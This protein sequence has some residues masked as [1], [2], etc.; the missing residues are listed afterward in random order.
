MSLQIVIPVYN[1]AKYLSKCLDSIMDKK[2]LFNG[3]VSVLVI[4]DGSTD[5][6]AE[7]IQEYQKKYPSIIQCIYQENQGL[8]E[9]RNRA[10]NKMTA[11]YFVFL[12][13][14]DWIETEK[15]L[16]L[17]NEAIKEDLDI[18][19]YR[20]RYVN[21][22]YEITGERPA[23]PVVHDEVITGYEVLKQ[24]YS[25]SSSCLFLYKTEFIIQNELF[26]HP[27]ITQQDVE[28][29]VRLFLKAR[30]VMFTDEVIYNYYR[31]VG[32]TTIPKS[33]KKLEKYLS[34]SITV[35]RLIKNNLAEVEDEKIKK[36]ITQLSN[37]VV[38]NLLWRLIQKRENLSYKCRLELITHLKTSKLYPIKPPFETNFQK[39]TSYA[40]NQ[41]WLLKFMMKI[42]SRKNSDQKVFEDKYCNAG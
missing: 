10:V 5:A 28:F 29:S 16:K 36:I 40:L 14:D 17:Y 22:D 32:S 18:L 6:S 8:S 31:R 7:I 12:D 20:L 26:Y 34:D 4:D 27:G 35:A 21:E 19:S 25:P 41:K 11:D 9:V 1:T 2:D 30:R 37:S 15:L 33:P 38:W 42:N 23:Q 13:S 39:I 3:E 24:G